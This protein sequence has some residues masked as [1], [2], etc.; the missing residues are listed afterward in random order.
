MPNL[1]QEV[2]EALRR[3]FSTSGMVMRDMRSE[4][5]ILVKGC[6]G[7]IVL[8]MLRFRSTLRFEVGG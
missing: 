6:S 5:G 7:I 4:L 8:L 3:L 1:S 2:V